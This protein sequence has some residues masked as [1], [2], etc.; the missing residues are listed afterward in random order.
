MIRSLVHRNRH[1]NIFAACSTRSFLAVLAL[2]ALAFGGSVLPT[3]AGPHF[4][5]P[6]FLG[7]P[8]AARSV[9]NRAVTM[10]SSV[11]VAKNGRLW[12]TWYAGELPGENAANYVVLATSGDEGKSWEEV[13]VVDPDGPGP[14]RS[15]DPEVWIAPNGQLYWFW[16]QGKQRRASD[17]AP[18][19]WDTD[20]WSLTIENPQ[21]ADSHYTQPVYLAEG[22]M[23]C[24]PI[25]LADG[26]WL[27]P[28]S[29]WKALENS[30][31]VVVSTDE[32]KTWH[33]KGSAN[34]P[35]DV[36]SFDE[37]MVVERLDGS[38]WM[39]VRTKYGIGESGSSDGGKTWSKLKPSSIP[40]TSSRF[41]IYRLAS[42]HLLL[43]RHDKSPE[44]K[45]IA[46][47]HLTAFLSQDDG[48]TWSKGM[49]IDECSSISYPDGQQAPDGTI[50]LTYDHGRVAEREILLVAFTESDVLAADHSNV[51]PMM[52]RELIS[53][54]SGGKEKEP[55]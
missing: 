36:R 10:V 6:A 44:S 52:R 33:V 5:T 32:G 17:I 26:E 39:L 37:H 55:K 7:K 27:L 25:T 4:A 38:L 15:Y 22:V 51:K 13:L 12:A 31:Q 23:M 29:L 54:G 28:V 35:T 49:L 20:L 8:D 40:H 48:K 30:A 53:K 41:F 47:S 16:A 24:K 14:I 9:T 2:V 11:A 42:G 21:E 34:V 18:A 1:R 19:G 50:Y 46:R 45:K 3:F 43:V